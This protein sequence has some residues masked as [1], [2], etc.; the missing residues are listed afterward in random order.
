MALLADDGYGP[1]GTQHHPPTYRPPAGLVR[2]AAF[3]DRILPM[4]VPNGLRS[5]TWGGANV[6]PRNVDNGLE[7]PAWSYW[8]SSVHRE[9]DGI[10]HMFV[11]RW[12][13]NDPRGHKAWPQSSVVHATGTSPA[14]PFTFKQ[15]IDKGHNVMCYRAKDGTYV[16]YVINGAYTAKSVDG[17]WTKYDLQ[18]DLRGMPKVPMSNHSFT[19]RE[20][21]SVLMVSRGGHIWISEDGLKP[22]RKITSVSLYP[23]IRGAFEDPVVWRDEVQYHLIVNDWKG[24][25]AFYLRSPDGVNWTWDEGKAYDIEV[26]RHP[27]GTREGWHKLERPNV[28]QDEHHRATHLYL[29]AMDAPKDLDLGSDGHSSKVLALPLTV[30]RRLEFIPAPGN[31]AENTKVQLKI[32]AEPGFDPALIDTASLRFGPS[33]EVNFGKGAK[34][35]ES[36]VSNGELTVSFVFSSA[37]TPASDPVVKLMGETKTGELVLGY[38]RSPGHPGLRPILSPQAPQLK[39]PG[40]LTVTVE[41]FGL[42]ASPASTVKVTLSGKG[43]DPATITSPLPSLEPYAATQVSLKID[44]NISPGKDIKVETTVGQPDAAST[45]TTELK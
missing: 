38:I 39:E 36:N 5:D 42:K 33:S 31:N 9:P 20:D 11:T 40:T 10:Y 28:L 2:G 30:E 8:C 1:T 24:R 35:I 13:E 12:P 15:E 19:R 6:K 4:P 16:L 14:G 45:I 22:F 32:A 34:A 21:G 23:K 7:D 3:I 37:R 26:V 17:P 29:A 43:L 44:P 41:N 25:T 27:D 18:Y